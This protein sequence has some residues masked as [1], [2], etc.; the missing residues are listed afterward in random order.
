M[1]IGQVDRIASLALAAAIDDPLDHRAELQTG[2]LG[3]IS[4]WLVPGI[5]TSARAGRRGD[6]FE[7]DEN[8]LR[9]I[10]MRMRRI[11]KGACIHQI[12]RRELRRPSHEWRPVEAERQPIALQLID[13]RRA[14][15][16]GDVDYLGTAGRVNCIR[17]LI[18]G[19]NAPA[20]HIADA[21]CCGFTFGRH[22][23]HC[24]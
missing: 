18:G 15:C 24:A 21:A 9:R 13:G 2:F 3:L 8:C 16:L 23:L 10:F 22:E 1:A 17:D 5:A 19:S 14:P 4:E 11:F 12:A 6:T 20:L 7:D